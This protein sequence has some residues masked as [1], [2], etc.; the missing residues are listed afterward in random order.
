MG[1][2]IV[3]LG[4]DLTGVEPSWDGTGAFSRSTLE[5]IACDGFFTGY[6]TAHEHAGTH[7]D[8]PAHSV[9]GG[10]TVD[11]L[12]PDRLVRPAVCLHV[13]AQ[14]ARNED[15]VVSRADVEAFEHVHGAIPEAALVV[16]STGWSQRWP[17]QVRYMNLREGVRHFP[18]LSVSAAELLTRHRRVAGIGVDTPSVDPGV[19][20]LFEVHRLTQAH[21]VYHIENLTALADLPPAGFTVV[22]A[23]MKIAGGSGGPARVFAILPSSS[24]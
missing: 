16:V 20:V 1:P 3:D 22:V 9:A 18:G 13:E 14:V 10:Q 15:Y 19:S 23:P 17:D 4:H 5:T 21:G 8:A 12:D 24:G 11:L 2:R 7:V 6:F